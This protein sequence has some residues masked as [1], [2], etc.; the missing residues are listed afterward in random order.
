M[1]S[2]KYN[3]QD[4]HLAE[5]WWKQFRYANHRLLQFFT[6]TAERKSPE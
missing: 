5:R 4:H 1:V 2:G 3:S 6:R